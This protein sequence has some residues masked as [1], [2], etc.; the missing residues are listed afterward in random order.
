MPSQKRINVRH[1]RNT[2]GLTQV[3]IYFVYC[4]KSNFFYWRKQNKKE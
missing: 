2:K 3:L 4:N 1:L